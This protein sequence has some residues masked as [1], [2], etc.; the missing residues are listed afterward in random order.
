MDLNVKNLILQSRKPSNNG[1]VWGYKKHLPLFTILHFSD[2]H[3]DAT[4]MKRLCDFMDEYGENID[5]C[6]CTG[7][8]LEG[9]L[10]SDFDFW[11][12]NGRGNKVLSCIGNHDLLLSHSTWDWSNLLSQEDAYKK[13]FAPYIANWNCVHQENKTY[14]YKDYVENAIRLIVLDSN[15]KSEELDEQ[16][17]WLEDVLNDAIKQELHVLIAMHHP[18]RMKKIPCNFSTLDKGDFLGDAEMDVFQDKVAEFVK[19]GGNFVVWLTGH[20]HYDYIGHSEKYPDQLC[21]TIEA[22]RCYQAMAYNDADRTE[23]M[24]SQDLYNIVTIDTADGLLKII[25]I[26]CDTDRFLRKKDTLCINYKTFEVIK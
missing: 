19:N 6:I 15:Q 17:N 4:G 20:I 5:D 7:D 10:E 14:Y 2:I 16:L 24:P 12:Q 25:R 8:I 3:G 11:A 22:L 13:F 21:I 1:K 23:G 26:G 18:I 9:S